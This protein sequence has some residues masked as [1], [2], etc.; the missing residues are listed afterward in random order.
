MNTR[1]SSKITGNKLNTSRGRGK[2]TGASASRSLDDLSR[3]STPR[4]STENSPPRCST[5]TAHSTGDPPECGDLNL[6][7]IFDSFTSSSHNNTIIA[8]DTTIISDFLSSLEQTSPLLGFAENSES[9]NMATDSNTQPPT[10]LATGENTNLNENLIT[11]IQEFRSELNALKSTISNQKFSQ[12][13]HPTVT[14]DN[15]TRSSVI[16]PLNSFVSTINQ[17]KIDLEKWKITFDG[18]GNV[19]DF[20]FKIDTLCK[21]TQCPHEH[22]MANFQIF[23]HGKAEKWYWE[24]IKQHNDP[25][26]SLL[27][28]SLKQ[29][30]GS[31][32]TDH[33]ILLRIH[34]RKQQPKEAYDDFHSSIISMS[35]R[36]QEPIAENRLI[37]ILKRNT[38]TNLRLMLFNTFP[39]SLHSLR[40]LAR[41][42]EKVLHES[43]I[44]LPHIKPSRQVNEV[45]Y[46]PVDDEESECEPDPQ[47]DALHFTRRSARTD[48]SKIKCWNCLKLGHSYI[49]CPDEGDRPKFCYLCGERGVVTPK[50]KNVHKGNRKRSEM[51][52]GDSCSKNQTPS[53]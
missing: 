23:L 8:Q 12:T 37:D 22:L 42:A 7:N 26:Y 3:P 4:P 32:E 29:E 19:S 49:Y 21:R 2:N 40:D 45:D 11:V 1:N 30:F 5:A 33:D 51:V 24:F 9:N 14:N 52:T 48:Y 27:E 17:N 34:M 31:S 47:V 20:L 43:K 38:I 28:Y 39:R 13:D 10:E 53:S 50:C 25:T 36:M 6:D 46:A 15:S 44:A 35:A 16:P 18:T 41:K